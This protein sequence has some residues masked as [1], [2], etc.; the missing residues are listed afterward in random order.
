[1]FED[2]IIPMFYD[3]DHK[4]I[5]EK[6]IG[7]IKNTISEIAPNYTTKRMLNDY[8]SR[9][10]THMFQQ[11]AEIKKDNYHLARKIASWK[12]KIL[13]AWD[14]IEVISVNVPDS[15]ASPLNQGGVF[16]AEVVLD[17]NELSAEDIGIEVI[18]GQ[19]ENDEVKEIILSKEMKMIG[20]SNGNVKY[21][22]E[23]PMDKAGVYDY[24]FRMFPKSQLLPHRQAFALVRWI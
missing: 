4:G 22:C 9:F 11:A 24:A 2:Q 16:T 19:K 14:D 20:R 13:N 17:L 15:T 8:F 7:Y 1:M 3:R 21:S 23:I 18:F 6:W 12:R 5:P 10:Y